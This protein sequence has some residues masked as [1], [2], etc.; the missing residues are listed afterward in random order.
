MNESLEQMVS[1]YRPENDEN[2]NENTQLGQ[3]EEPQNNE[4]QENQQE[5]DIS[6]TNL[7]TWFRNNVQ[8]FDNIFS[9]NATLTGVDTDENLI[10]TVK[11]QNDSSGRRR[12]PYVFRGS[13]NVF[14]LDLPGDE[15]FIYQ[16][17]TFQINYRYSD[18]IFIKTYNLRRGIGVVYCLYDSNNNTIPVKIEKYKK[19]SE[20]R[21][22]V[23]DD[24]LNI[25]ID[26][27]L[28]QTADVEGLIIKYKQLQKSREEISTNRDALEF[29]KN[30]Q[31]NIYDINHLI[32]IDT[33]IASL[34]E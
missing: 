14:V 11:D 22:P 33:I 9:V 15:M 10:M 12:Y 6:I 27:I 26:D 8:N 17:N 25:N 32:Q 7:T 18:N 29:F 3:V 23:P 19:I 4:T 20:N 30:R 24:I 28:S 16:N 34:F 13:N 21:I 1:S 31:S 2:Q 5:D